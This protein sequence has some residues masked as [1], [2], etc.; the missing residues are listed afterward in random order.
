MSRGSLRNEVIER[1][2]TRG[3]CRYTRQVAG[4]SRGEKWSRGV[5]RTRCYRPNARSQMDL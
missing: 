4:G 5:L 2:V 1:S 3:V